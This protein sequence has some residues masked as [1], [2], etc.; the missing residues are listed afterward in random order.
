MKGGVN[1]MEDERQLVKPATITVIIN[2]FTLLER[3]NT[4]SQE[5][6][7]DWISLSIRLSGGL[8]MMWKK[9]ED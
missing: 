3:L 6:N 5:Y 7:K 4:I 2:D 1:T 8:L 9:F